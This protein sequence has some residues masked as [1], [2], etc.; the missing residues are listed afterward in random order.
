MKQ[1]SMRMLTGMV[2]FFVASTGAQAIIIS[3]GVTGGSAQ[4]GG[5]TFIELTS[6][7]SSPVTGASDVGNNTFQ[8]LNLYGFNEDQ[9]IVIP[10][11][12]AVDVG[13]SPIAAGTVVASHYIFFDPVSASI[14]G[15][16]D[17]DSQ[18]LGILTST[19]NMAATDF[20]ANTSVNYLNP[21]AR[22]LEGGDSAVIDGGNPNRV[23]VSFVASTPGDYIRVLTARSPGAAMPEPDTVL[24]LAIGLAG[25]AVARRRRQRV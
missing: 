23:D 6:S 9:N 12:L 24:L 4:S 16:V 18:I 25:V 11:N 7:F 10:S 19:S 21:S 22:G 2:L 5:A 3:G 17:F 8:T 14:Q 15:Y 20:L 13:S 1:T